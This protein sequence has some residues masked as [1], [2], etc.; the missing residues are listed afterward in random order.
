M[1]QAAALE[2]HSPTFRVGVSDSATSAQFDFGGPVEFQ[3]FWD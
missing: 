2:L 3:S 1:V